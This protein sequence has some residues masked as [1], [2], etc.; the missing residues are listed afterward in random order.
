MNI[1]QSESL[2][3][4]IMYLMGRW[5]FSYDIYI[6]KDCRGYSC[7]YLYIDIVQYNALIIRTTKR[8]IKKILHTPS[9]H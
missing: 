1:I 8:H 3:I 7:S 4:I 6:C 5:V 9:T 2:H